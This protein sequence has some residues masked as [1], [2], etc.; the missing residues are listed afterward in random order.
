MPRVIQTTGEA[1]AAFGLSEENFQ[2]NIAPGAYSVP[3][4]IEGGNI[5]DATLSGYETPSFIHKKETQLPNIG[6]GAMPFA[7]QQ[8][9]EGSIH[10]DINEFSAEF[11]TCLSMKDKATVCN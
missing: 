6:G 8:T 9:L 3:V 7:P 10:E 5:N 2:Q 4:R 11:N 1:T